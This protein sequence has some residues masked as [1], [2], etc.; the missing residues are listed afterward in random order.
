[1]RQGPNPDADYEIRVRDLVAGFTTK[2]TEVV[3]ELALMR[4]QQMG[5]DKAQAAVAAAT[6]KAVEALAERFKDGPD[7]SSICDKHS[8]LI[9]EGSSRLTTLERGFSTL[10]GRLWVIALLILTPVLGSLVTSV[11]VAI[12]LAHPAGP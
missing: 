2:I 7:Y 3:T 10:I 1:M 11:W 4:S 12:K 6:E 8:A 5:T 9:A